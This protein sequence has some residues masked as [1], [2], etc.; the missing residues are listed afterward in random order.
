MA[1]K[2]NSDLIPDPEI[3]PID[4][5]PAPSAPGEN[6][7]H[8]SA[9]DEGADA[10]APP[11]EAPPAG[12]EQALHSSDSDKAVAPDLKAVGEFAE[13]VTIGHPSVEANPAFSLFARGEFDERK[14]DF[15]RGILESEEFGVR[16]EEIELQLSSGKL[17]VPR[18]S[19]YAAILLG[20][21]IYDIVDTVE[22]FLADE[23]D[24]SMLIDPTHYRKRSAEA[25][26]LGEE[27]G[28]EA[29]VFTS[30]VSELSGFVI[31]RILSAITLSEIISAE[32]A[33][34][35]KSREFEEVT[36][37]LTTQLASK[38]FKLGAH[39]VIGVSFAVK[40]VDG[41]RNAAGRTAKAYRIL[42]SGTAVRAKKV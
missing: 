21:K 7:E 13:K 12:L 31:T 14:K 28:S 37:K 27:P 35:P 4:L 5:E 6:P 3:V 42:A 22:V 40:A 8:F 2:E 16:F 25:H 17:L 38:A 1:E 36:E 24:E 32:I 19:E 34:D 41:Y 33:E 10:A 26:D 18:I 20:Q 9:L 39:G 29:D 30:T 23:A 11:V 15:I